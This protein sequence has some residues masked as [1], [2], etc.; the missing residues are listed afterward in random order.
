MRKSNEYDFPNTPD[1]TDPKI[2]PFSSRPEE[3]AGAAGETAVVLVPKDEA[4]AALAFPSRAM[5]IQI[6]DQTSLDEANEVVRRGKTGLL[7][8]AGVFDRHIDRAFEQHRGLL[9]EKRRFTEPLK[10][11]LDIV[12]PKVANYLYEEDQKRLAEAR[13]RQLALERAE[14]KAEETVDRAQ[15]LI[16]N[17]QVA[18]ANVVIEKGYAK[19]EELRRAI[20]EV[21]PAAMAAGTSLRTTWKFE[22]TDEAALPHEY[23]MPNLLLIGKIVTATK[24]QT[25]IPGVRVYPVRGISTRLDK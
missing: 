6:S 4:A 14:R 2:N 16:Q 13:T 19:V 15:E 3:P 21:A 25:R 7:F 9:A 8:F 18:K 23:L 22:I 20:P 12:N 5:A 11:G 1:F 17:G 24:D 10:R